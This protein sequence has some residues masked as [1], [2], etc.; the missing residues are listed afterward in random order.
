MGRQEIQTAD[1]PIEQK[2]D[3]SAEQ[4]ADRA[5]EIVQ[6]Q[7]LPQKDYLDELA[8][9]E[10][11]VTIRIEPSTEKNAAT[12]HYCAVNGKGVEA[13]DRNGQWKEIT[14]LPVGIELTIKRKYVAV[15]ASAKFDTI[16]TSVGEQ[17]D[18]GFIANDVKRRTSGVVVFSVLQDKNPLGAAWLTEYRRRNF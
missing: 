8:F 11:P 15:L 10:E 3:I 16:D 2:P 14:Y 5:P 17:R 4:L 9:N 7:Q 13:L 1:I 18:D 6:A 12:S